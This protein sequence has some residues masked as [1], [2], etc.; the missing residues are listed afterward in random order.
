MFFKL[1]VIFFSM[2]NL[3]TQ[4][5]HTVYAGNMYFQPTDIVINQGDS[6]E[7]I[8]EGGYHD[9]VVTVGPE[10]LELPA[11]SGPCNIGTLVFNVAGNYDYECSVGSHAEA[12]MIGTITVNELEQNAQV[13]ILHNSPHP[14][15]DIYVDGAIA[16]EDVAYRT[17]TGLIDLPVNTEVGIAPA[18]GDVIATFPF[19]LAENGSYVVVASGIVGDDTH[20]FDLLAST[21][22][23]AA[24]DNEHFGLKVMHGVT[25][26]PAVDIY[27][28][29][30]LLV[31]NLAYGEFQGYLQVPVGDYTLDITGHGST[32]P[33]ASFSA[34]LSSFGG[35]SGVVYASGFLAPTA[36]DSAFT[37]ILTTPSGY[38]V[39]LPITETALDLFDDV[40]VNTPDNF[41]VHQNYPNPFNPVTLIEYELISDS[42]VNI[43]IYDLLGNVIVELYDGYQTSGINRI[44]WDA[45]NSYGDLMSAG[46]YFYKI[47]AG[48]SSQVKR[49]MLLK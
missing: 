4:V 20:P 13:Q 49:M 8:N 19:E 23:P 37:L 39:E 12:G 6:I 10:M 18:D 32:D 38:D 27:A 47:Q 25:D 22:E 44:K 43:S 41:V 46:I 1:F 21:L 5:L 16:L 17:S 40:Y 11:C 9:V 36:T 14:V 3:Y 26:A 33:V 7:F 48:N 28:N 2:T 31:E 24:V 34:P 42:K 15:V 30:S 35:F 29:G 45:R